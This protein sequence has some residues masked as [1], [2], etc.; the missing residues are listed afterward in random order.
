M[1]YYA[2]L[3]RLQFRLELLALVVMGSAVHVL[4]HLAGDCLAQ[5]SML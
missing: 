2:M 3:R 4:P 1:P 5:C